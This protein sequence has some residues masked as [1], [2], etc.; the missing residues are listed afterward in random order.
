MLRRAAQSRWAD[1]IWEPH[2]VLADPGG[3]ARLLREDGAFA[4]WLHPG[5]KLLLHKDE[6]D[7]YYF[8]VSSQNPRVFILWRMDDERAETLK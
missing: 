6:L 7:G 1:S 4:Q 2:G 8:N 5:F 3:E